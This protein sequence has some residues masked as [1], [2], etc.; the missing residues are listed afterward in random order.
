MNPF[1]ERSD[2]VDRMELSFILARYIVSKQVKISDDLYYVSYVKVLDKET[3][4][5]SGLDYIN[6]LNTLNVSEHTGNN[7]NS[8]ID[9]ESISTG[10][11]ILSYARVYMAKAMLYVIQNGGT[12]YYTDTDSLVIDIKLPLSMTD[13]K[14]LGLFKLEVLVKQGYFLA[15]KVYAIKPQ[16]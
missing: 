2:L 12:I 5:K 15:D 16:N 6:E 7:K 10:A 13:P 4:I 8:N 9:F 3:C 1:K 14:K 11:A